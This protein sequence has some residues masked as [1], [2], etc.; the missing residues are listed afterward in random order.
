MVLSH[1]F[2]NLSKI[3]NLAPVEQRHTHHIEG[4]R[5]WGEV[6]QQKGHKEGP[7]TP[8]THALNPTHTKEHNGAQTSDDNTELRWLGITTKRHTMLAL[9]VESWAASADELAAA[10]DDAAS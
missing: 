8:K 3:Y 10:V 6:G 9:K 5:K 1:T 4:E 7:H 2:N